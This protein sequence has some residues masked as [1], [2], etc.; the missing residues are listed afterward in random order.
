MTASML[1]T[2]GVCEALRASLNGCRRELYIVVD[3]IKEG[4]EKVSHN[5]TTT[6]SPF[7]GCEAGE[8]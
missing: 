8:Q 2:N 5:V 7:S 4:S 6:S 1:R 3:T